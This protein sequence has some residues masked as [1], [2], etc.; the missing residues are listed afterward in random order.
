M[1]KYVPDE[2]IRPMPFTPYGLEGKGNGGCLPFS[3]DVTPAEDLKEMFQPAGRSVGDH[4][5]HSY[6]RQL[7]IHF[8][9]C[10]SQAV[11][12]ASK[13]FVHWRSKAERLR[14]VADDAAWM[15]E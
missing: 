5:R 14:A 10:Q 9:R 13:R 15:E 6:Q 12:L 4:L 8:L 2:T 3:E 1:R 7:A 11:K